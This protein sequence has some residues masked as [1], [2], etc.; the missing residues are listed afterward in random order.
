MHSFPSI[1]D[2]PSELKDYYLQ[3][4]RFIGNF[5]SPYNKIC[6]EVTE[7]VIDDN[8]NG[9][10]KNYNGKRSDAIHYSNSLGLIESKSY[11]FPPERPK[12]QFE[13]FAS[14]LANRYKNNKYCNKVKYCIITAKTLGDKMKRF[15]SVDKNTKRLKYTDTNRYFNANGNIPIFFVKK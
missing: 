3:K 7:F 2:F 9:I 14:F 12:K 6:L 4:A 11:N 10:Y 15:V 1:N 5:P 8:K 13:E